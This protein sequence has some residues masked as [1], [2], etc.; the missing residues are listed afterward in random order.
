MNNAGK[1]IAR[2][3]VLNMAVVLLLLVPAGA[4][5]ITVERSE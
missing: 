4:A 3:V 2:V 1:R 5:E